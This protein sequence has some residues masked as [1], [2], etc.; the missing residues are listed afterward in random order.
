MN[1]HRSSIF[2]LLLTALLWSTG[3]FLIK[4]VVWHPLAIAGGRS[5]IAAIVLWV[6]L[7]K[8]QFNWSPIQIIGALCYAATV[9][10]FVLANKMTTAANA[11]LLQYTGPIYVALLSSWL[12]KER[13]TKIDWLSIITAMFGMA[14]FFLDSLSTEGMLGNIIA[15][16]AGIAFAGLAISLRKQK[17]GSPTESILLGNILTAIIGIPFMID[18]G[19]PNNESIIG[20]V[21]LGTIQLG[22]PYILYAKAIKHVTALES[23]LI[24]VLEPLLNPLWVFMAHGEKP[25]TW[26]NIGGAIVLIA[27]LGRSVLQKGLKKS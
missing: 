10:L 5:A 14:L 25:G 2:L 24:P 21:L 4:L 15:I 11:I 13:I 16:A 18:S 19:L 22:L 12:L 8:P 23:V 17:E 7:K 26:A 3:G 9:I 20:I 1:N 27:I 6:F